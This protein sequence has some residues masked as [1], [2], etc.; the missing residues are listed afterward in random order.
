MK[1]SKTSIS[2]RSPRKYYTYRNEFYS[3]SDS[4]IE[5]NHKEDNS[6][7][8]NFKEKPK[9]TIDEQKK[10][11]WSTLF[12]KFINKAVFDEVHSYVEINLR[13]KTLKDLTNLP[14]NM[15]NDKNL[16]L[17]QR[18]S[19][20]IIKV[21]NFHKAERTK[22]ITTHNTDK[23]K[24][25]NRFI[26]NILDS[27]SNNNEST[28]LNSNSKNSTLKNFV[29]S[30]TRLEKN[31]I[32]SKFILNEDKMFVKSNYNSPV[33]QSKPNSKGNYFLYN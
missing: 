25:R 32:R 28:T 8:I 16:F 7:V 2:I 21:P 27:Y 24:V 22:Y 4:E 14:P 20:K 11:S 30:P 26:A 19:L 23:D 1:K 18:R 31:K 13:M 10:V 5:S 33:K 15:A 9:R 29:C 6:C 12:E 17:N 3:S